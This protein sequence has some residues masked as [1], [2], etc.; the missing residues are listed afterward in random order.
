[1][2]IQDKLKLMFDRVENKQPKKTEKESQQSSTGAS[3]DSASDKV[4]LSSHA[5][6]AISLAQALKD[7]PEVRQARV[8]ELKQRLESGTYDVSGNAV[9]ESIMEKAVNDLF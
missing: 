4:S 3:S 5:N 9:A 6:K 7:S 8:D 2:R 1:M